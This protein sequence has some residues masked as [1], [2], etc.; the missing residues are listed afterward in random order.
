MRKYTHMSFYEILLDAGRSRRFGHCSRARGLQPPLG[1]TGVVGPHVLTLMAM[2][3]DNSRDVE[4]G[5]VLRVDL[6]LIDDLALRPLDALKTADRFELV[7]EWRRRASTPSTC[8]RQPAEWIARMADPLLALSTVDRLQR[9]PTSWSWTTP[10]IGSGRGPSCA[11][12]NADTGPEEAERRRIWLCATSSPSEAPKA[13]GITSRP[14]PSATL[15]SL[16]CFR[17]RGRHR[18]CPPDRL[19]KLRGGPSKVASDRRPMSLK[20][21]H[22]TTA[23]PNGGRS[24]LH[25]SSAFYTEQKI[26]AGGRC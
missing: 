2:R 1:D 8:N 16:R 7:V 20:A 22:G 4:V 17:P 26:D 12:R 18:S 10:R 5:R 19:S 21:S 13:T 24:A 3:L 9:P 11:C 6:L 15:T 25:S 14:R 23:L